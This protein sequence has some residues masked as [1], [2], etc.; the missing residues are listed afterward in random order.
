MIVSAWSEEDLDFLYE[1][2]AFAHL[3]SADIDA[4]KPAIFEK[5]SSGIYDMLANRGNEHL[6]QSW[7]CKK[8][9]ILKGLK[10]RKA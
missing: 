8:I 3:D 4:L 9:E 10:F 7:A 2:E 6:E 5:V 1:E